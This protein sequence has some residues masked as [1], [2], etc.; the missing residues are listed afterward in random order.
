MA[1][2]TA[3]RTSS[4]PARGRPFSPLRGGGEATAGLCLGI[5]AVALFLALIS[6]T[7]SDLPSWVPF[8]GNPGD[9]AIG[10]NLM[11]P[12]GSIV[13]GYLIFFWGPA[14]FFLPPVFLWWAIVMILTGRFRPA[15]NLIA[16]GAFLGAAVSLIEFQRFLFQDWPA[17]YNLPGSAGGYFGTFIGRETIAELLGLPGS[18]LLVSATYAASLLV[19]A[20]IHPARFF[21]EVATRTAAWMRR[22]KPL[23][24]VCAAV[25]A[26]LPAPG[27]GELGELI[28]SPRKAPEPETTPRIPLPQP[29]PV[30]VA[31]PSAIAP[32]RLPPSLDLLQPPRRT[33][34]ETDRAA[35][36]AV[37]HTI[38]RTLRSFG[39]EV[40]PGNITR[41]TTITRFEIYPA[42]GLRVNR[43][44]ALQAD[45]ARAIRAEKVHILA[46]IPGKD[47]VG[48]EIANSKRVPVPLREVLED[49]A[50]RSTEVSLPLAL[51]KDVYGQAVI[52]DLARMPHLLVA[53]ATGSGKSVCINTMIA[54][55]L[56][57]FAPEELRFLMIDPKRVEMQLYDR[58]PH[59]L[60]PVLY[61]SS[62]VLKAL[63]WVIGEMERRYGLLAEAGARN[64]QAYRSIVA[65]QEEQEV[66]PYIVVIIDELADLM[67]TVPADVETA[68]ARIAQKARAAGIH[69]IIATQTPRADVITGVIK[70]NIPS[71]IA[72]QV[73][74]K[75]DSRIILDEN[76][77]EN[78]V[79]KGDMLFLPP[80]SAQLIRLQG[81][82][83]T[84]EEA[85]ALVG[86][87]E[88]TSPQNRHAYGGDI[89]ESKEAGATSL[90][91]PSEDEAMIE[92]CLEVFLAE[93]KAS[94]SLLQ[95]R[96]RLGYTRAARILDILESRGVIGPS[97]GAKPREILV[98][99]PG[100]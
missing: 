25:R 65:R 54:S 66:L 30:G 26:R 28:E 80:G 57:R 11:G 52:G 32:R 12:A 91:K 63:R 89:L 15:R 22:V 29:P 42:E 2:R 55:L 62:R 14:S 97:N 81:A 77:A 9:G 87:W 95:R 70:A 100:E 85:E 67:Q 33:A 78:L 99:L 44:T 48:I 90:E 98:D 51:G 92:Q 94:T 74:S 6:Y 7:P 34:G 19:L 73:A 1:P 41:G 68:I 40:E 79:G 43:I 39:V 60:A 75:T 17:R 56:F 72:F 10:G 76:G 31:L 16:L 21:G 13:A 35:L 27:P 47:T 37:Q 18:W 3:Q 5:L 93:G 36:L 69:L 58:L 38:V 59:L 4:S 86:A 45:I 8:S 61:E 20:G 49:R 50:F 71:R 64:L 83:I 46:P 88:D 24:A 82:L 53:G 23:Q 84:D 96:L